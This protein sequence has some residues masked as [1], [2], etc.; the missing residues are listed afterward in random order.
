MSNYNELIEVFEA[1]DRGSLKSSDKSEVKSSLITAQDSLQ[2]GD[3][4]EFTSCVVE[5]VELAD[6]CPESFLAV[7]KFLGGLAASQR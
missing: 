6:S 4:K 2:G 7:L 5:A 1:I 3:L